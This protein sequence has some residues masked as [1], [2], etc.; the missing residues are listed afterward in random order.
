MLADER[1]INLRRYP[2]NFLVQLG[3]DVGSETLELVDGMFWTLRYQFN[4]QEVVT[5]VEYSANYGDLG[6]VLLVAHPLFSYAANGGF[7]LLGN[8]QDFEL[9]DG[10]LLMVGGTLSNFAATLKFQLTGDNAGV[11]EAVDKSVGINRSGT[12]A[13]TVL[14]PEERTA[15]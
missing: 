9:G 14:P 8:V 13:V 2:D 11:F 1:Q 15:P 10:S 4:G 7:L 5:S 12:F 3:D 6:N